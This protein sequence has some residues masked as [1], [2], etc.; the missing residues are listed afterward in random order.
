MGIC[1]SQERKEDP[2]LSKLFHTIPYKGIKI[3][4][5]QGDVLQERADAIVNSSEYI[6]I[7]QTQIMTYAGASITNNLKKRL[8]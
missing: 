5:I 8:A 1:V 4:I 6:T 7:A 2:V 3:D